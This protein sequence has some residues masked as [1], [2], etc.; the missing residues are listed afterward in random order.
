M[1]GQSGRDDLFENYIA[2]LLGPNYEQFVLPQV[3]MSSLLSPAQEIDPT[4]YQRVDFAIFHPAL[5][6]K[7]IV[8]IDGKQH[9]I[10]LDR[11]RV[12][13]LKENGYTVI[14]IPVE[15]IQKG[16]VLTYLT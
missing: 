12:N 1:A 6:E 4:G 15:E 5:K 9:K 7:I 3:Q 13:I 11:K 14:N 10:E 16:M 8:E 2:D